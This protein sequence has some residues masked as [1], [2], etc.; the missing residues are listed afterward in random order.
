MREQ[1]ACALPGVSI[2]FA[3]FVPLMMRAVARGYVSHA[4]AA[5]V[6]RGL[7]EGFDLG[8]DV[9]RMHGRRRYRNY[10]SA[11]EARAAV[12]RATAKRV[13]QLK[14]MRL[15]QFEPGD[16]H[17][18]PF[19]VWRIFPMGAVPKALEPGEYRPFSDHTR[20][21]LRDATV[22]DGLRHTLRTCLLYTSPSPRDS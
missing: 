9:S 18:I 12:T 14:T 1:G 13:A 19:K 3:L 7:R 20:T 16:R 2:D 10:P 8:I 22:M 4:K 15:C 6:E 11:Y 17:L 21:G 5:F